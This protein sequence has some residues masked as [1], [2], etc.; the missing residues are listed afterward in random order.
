M[1]INIHPLLVHFPIALLTVYSLLEII[2]VGK[3]RNLPYWFYIK[4]ILLIIGSIST[5][6]TILSGLIIQ[7]QFSTLATLVT[8]H[9][10]FG[11]LTAITYGILG[12]IYIYLWIAKS[13]NKTSLYSFFSNQFFLNI[14][15]LL[16]LII[17]LITGALGGSIVYGPN[18][19]FFTSF[20]YKLFFH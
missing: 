16:G 2:S 15:A 19:D 13:R 6:P 9:S 3:I 5:L 17:V 10:Q 1:P 12:I 4:A 7:N 20:I 8:L 14:L 11:K 18:L